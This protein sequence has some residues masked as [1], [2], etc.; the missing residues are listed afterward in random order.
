MFH[1]NS[2]LRMRFCILLCALIISVSLAEQYS[3][4]IDEQNGRYDE[5]IC[6]YG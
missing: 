6:A 4:V 2:L 1:S 5:W 3:A